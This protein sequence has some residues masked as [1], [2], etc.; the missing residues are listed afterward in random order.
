MNAVRGGTTLILPGGDRTHEV[1]EGPCAQG[2]ISRE[3][4]GGKGV[5]S[6]EL[7]EGGA[8]IRS[9]RKGRQGKSEC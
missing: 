8:R 9:P 4:F 2:E 1:L 3:E 6:P 5:S 7:F